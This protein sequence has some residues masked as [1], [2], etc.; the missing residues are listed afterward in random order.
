VARELGRSWDTVNAIALEATR[1]LLVTAGPARLDGVRV[2]GVDEHKW[3]HVLG[4]DADGFVTVITDLTA[5]GAGP[6]ARTAARHGA[7][8]LRGSHGRLAR[9]P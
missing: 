8:A 7:R 4:A 6:G 5:V 2:I 3:S 1:E 9:G